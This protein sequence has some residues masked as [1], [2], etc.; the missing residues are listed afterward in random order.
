M[1]GASLLQKGH[2]RKF[3]KIRKAIPENSLKRCWHDLFS[4]SIVI[5]CFGG[6]G[7]LHSHVHRAVQTAEIS[8]VWEMSC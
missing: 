8:A 2:R 7:G 4:G 1:T 5:G 3:R 6:G